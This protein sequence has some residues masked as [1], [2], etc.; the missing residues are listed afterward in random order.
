VLVCA[1]IQSF[2]KLRISRLPPV[3]SS[4]GSDSWE[5]YD[6]AY[7]EYISSKKNGKEFGLTWIFVYFPFQ[8]TGVVTSTDTLACAAVGDRICGMYIDGVQYLTAEKDLKIGSKSTLSVL[9]P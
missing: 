8:V 4:L 1:R 7:V 6:Y 3:G 5:I 9:N 2:G